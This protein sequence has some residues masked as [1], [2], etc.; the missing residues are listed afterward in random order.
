MRVEKWNAMKDGP[1]SD[2]AMRQK[3][4]RMGYDV[5]RYVYPP[6]MYFPD[7]RHAVDKIDAVVSG[8]LRMTALGREVVLGAGDYGAVPKG[9]IHNAEVIGFDAVVSL[10]A[11]RELEEEI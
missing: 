8:R 2:N 3:L 7:H 11:T 4:E 10:D 5:T 1:F 9:V 6:G